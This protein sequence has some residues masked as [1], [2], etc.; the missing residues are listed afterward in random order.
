MDKRTIIKSLSTIGLFY[1]VNFGLWEV[2]VFLGMRE[3]W[4]SFAVYAVLI[5]IVILMW[6][7]KLKSEWQRL[8]SELKNWKKFIIEMIVW[9]IV[10]AALG[11]LL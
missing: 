9:L 2:F 4:A 7:S 5:V 8:K 10:A 11:Y 6:H 3:T 1:L